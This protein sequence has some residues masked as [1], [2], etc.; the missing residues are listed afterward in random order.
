MKKSI[1]KIIAVCLCATVAFGGIVLNASSVNSDDNTEEE[2]K[3]VSV[4][5]ENKN[6][7]NFKDET[8]YI[9][10]N[11]DG[12]TD[13]IIVSD[14]IKNKLKN[15][16][17][18]DITELA[19]I[20]NIKGSETYT[21][22]SGNTKVWDAEGNDIYYQGNIDKEL[23]VDLK[24]SYKLDGVD[25]SPT[26]LV[27][28]SGKVTIRFDY[29]NKQFEY[30]EIEGKKEKIYV[31]Y[32]MLTGVVLDNDIFRNVDITNGKLL[33]DGS[34]TVV[35]GAAFPGLQENLGISKEDFEIP[36]YVEITADAENFEIGMTVT[37]AT[38][39]LFNEIDLGGLDKADN[40]KESVKKLTDGMDMLLDG[41]SELYDGLS[42][43][44]DKSGDLTGGIGQLANG[45]GSLKNGTTELDEGASS[46]QSGA[47]QLS[48]GLNTLSSENDKLNGGAK[49]VFETLLSTANN[50]L[51]AA[52]LEVPTLTIDN[53]SDVLDNVIASLDKNEVYKK[54][55][56]T[57][58]AAVEEKRDYIT[59]QVTAAVRQEVEKQVTAAVKNK[60][61]PKVTQAVRENVRVQVLSA[62]N[63]DA[64][65]YEAAVSAGLID[66][67]TQQNI[68]NEIEKQMK[69]DTVLQTI[70][71]K[72]DEQMDS[73]EI[74][75]TIEENV[76]QQMKT[77]N[78]KEQITSNTEAQVQK[79]V[80]DN[81]ASNEV[82]SQLT[83]ASEGVE[84]VASLKSSLDS[85]NT[86]YTGLQT[87]TGGVSQ[88][89]DGANKLKDGA[90]ELKKGT[91]Q[92]N[93]GSVELY[94]GIL[95]LKKSTPDLINGIK[96][97]RDGSGQLKDGLVE[98]NEEGIQRLSDIVNKNLNNIVER[99]RATKEVS[100]NY[101]SFAGIS[102]NT[103]GQVK[104]IYRT[105]SLKK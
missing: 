28:K 9:L 53:Y 68:E 105:D 44:L 1:I 83:A 8:V 98:F 49:Q 19:D 104:F 93:S 69:S 70:E 55:L 100:L 101:K 5:K 97:L 17:L 54:A 72:T 15:K 23:P 31:P 74:K 40:L 27:G 21:D 63:M 91:E 80:S 18:S 38:N 103:D 73:E 81:M 87:Y 58:K 57:V 64:A 47:E 43:L 66:K 3:Q 39:E 36:D 42:D 79:A 90:C 89:A 11:A 56:D 94:D 102:N 33:N 25:I 52:G 48:D 4:D 76:A 78:V 86:F 82:Q 2:S 84:S 59:E 61:M 30:K 67:A 77:D 85:Y 7:S 50:Q 32:A 13:K 88:A 46:L 51:A 96:Q 26:E 12:S 6:D 16:S 24:I 20:E 35:V 62:I 45:A 14:W 75:A 92:L 99:M 22:G 60:V 65:S 95:A 71:A 10:A 34:R 29:T 37:L 41:S